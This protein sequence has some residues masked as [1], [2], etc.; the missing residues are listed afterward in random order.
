M[1]PAVRKPT[2]NQTDSVSL[3]SKGLLYLFF[4]LFLSQAP[5]FGRCGFYR[6]D[7]LITSFSRFTEKQCLNLCN[8]MATRTM[9]Q[10]PVNKITRIHCAMHRYIFIKRCSFVL[11]NQFTSVFRASACGQKFGEI[12]ILKVP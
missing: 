2:T 3:R 4:L 11:N 8:N 12:K 9:Y 6:N 5:L 7:K 10:M 1:N